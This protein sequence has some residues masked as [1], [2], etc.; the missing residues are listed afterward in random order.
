MFLVRFYFV[1]DKLFNLSL[2]FEQAAQAGLDSCVDHVGLELSI[3]LTV[4]PN[5][6]DD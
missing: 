2:Y 4:F 5:S 1:W 3:F 6:W